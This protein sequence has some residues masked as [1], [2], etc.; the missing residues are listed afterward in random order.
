MEIKQQW[1]VL[2]G[3]IIV[4]F[5]TY[6]N[7]ITNTFV[8]KGGTQLMLCYNLTRFQEDID[9]DSKD[10]NFFK[11]VEKFIDVYKGNY[12]E[13]WYRKQKDTDTVKRAYIHY[14]GSKP[15]KIEVQY[16]DYINPHNVVTVNNILV[17][18]INT[19]AIKKA[20]AFQHRDKVRDLYDIVF[21]Y[22]YYRNQ[23][24]DNTLD[25]IRD[26]L[27]FKGLEQFDYLMHDKAN[28]DP[29]IDYNELLNDFIIMYQS[30]GLQ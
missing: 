17:Y 22:K 28:L 4:D 5:V 7:S 25:Q 21:I 19:L 26:V 3:Q 11:Y 18:S 9:L 10:K 14:G 20:N 30:L 23:L 29:L 24:T 12:S 13:L 15:L 16:R 27:A 6:L 1:Q 2:H 8:I